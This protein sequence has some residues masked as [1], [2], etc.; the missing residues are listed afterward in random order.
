MCF[1]VSQ[2]II[3][4]FV[5][6]LKTTEMQMMLC[7][8]CMEESFLEKE[9]LLSML[10]DPQEDHK[11]RAEHPSQHGLT[12]KYK[13]SHLHILIAYVQHPIFSYRSRYG[14]PVRTGYKLIVENL[15]SR[16]S[17]QVNS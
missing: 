13:K 12:S 9:W 5:R 16:V 3:L 17:W 2:M 6:I 15:S 14:A 1:W 4:F 11:G 7:M 10:K 8:N